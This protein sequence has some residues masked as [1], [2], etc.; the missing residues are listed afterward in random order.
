MIPIATLNQNTVFV[1]EVTGWDLHTLGPVNLL[2]FV[3][4]FR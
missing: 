1:L 3:T 2:I 4:A